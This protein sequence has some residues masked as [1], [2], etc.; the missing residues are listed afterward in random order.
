MRFLI[1]S[2]L[3][4]AAATLGLYQMLPLMHFNTKLTALLIGFFLAS[5]F[6]LFFFIR[7]LAK[8]IS[9]N[10]KMIGIFI[11]AS[12]FLSIL[13]TFLFHLSFPQKEIVLPN[14][15]IHID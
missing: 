10:H 1:P 13:I 5:T 8:K 2:G 4:S 9:I 11:V 6:F 15:K 14:R 12:V 3:I 7:F